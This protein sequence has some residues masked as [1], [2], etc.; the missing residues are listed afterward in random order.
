VKAASSTAAT[1]QAD[2]AGI[3]SVIDRARQVG[4]TWDSRFSAIQGPLAL[5]VAVVGLWLVGRLSGAPGVVTAAIVVAA[6]S[7]LQWPATAAAL[8]CLVLLF[9]DDGRHVAG[10]LILVLA[11]GIG[12]LVWSMRRERPLGVDAIVV[13]AALLLA[14]TAIALFATLGGA[15]PADAVR[16]SVRWIGLASGLLLLPIQLFLIR[17]DALRPALILGGGVVVALGLALLA[18]LAPSVA[19]QTPLAQLLSSVQSDRATGPFDS[20]NR[21]GSVA[22]MTLI[23]ALG[24]TLTT[25]DRVRRTI[26]A[27]VIVIAAAALLLSFS[28]GAMLGVG[29]AVSLILA[30]RSPR[31]GLA[32]GALLLAAGLAVGPFIISARLGFDTGSRPGQ[33]AADDDE[34]LAAWRA[35]IEMFA[36]APLTGHGYGSFAWIATEGGATGSLQTAHNEVIGLL[37]ETGLPGAAA[38]VAIFAIVLVRTLRMG[39]RAVIALGAATVFAVA[40]MFNVQSIYPQVTVVLWTSVAYGL[41]AMRPQA[42][43]VPEVA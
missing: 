36:T 39:G 20:P 22:G 33:L 15:A 23:A 24:L 8:A 28:R 41:V 40:T 25:A 14:A 21:L 38:F 3:G 37:A 27:C 10:G 6:V 43:D 31:L 5:D 19:A 11:A 26:L 42:R 34:R 12:Q 32:V 13:A 9:P 4:A 1:G 35:G 30:L 29:V 7:G 16:S 18:Q 2:A 17:Q